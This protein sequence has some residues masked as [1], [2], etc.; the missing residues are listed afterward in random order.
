MRQCIK[1]SLNFKILPSFPDFFPQNWICLS[2]GPW[3]TGKS[4]TE[5]RIL[6]SVNSQYD[7]RLFIDLQLQYKK[8]T[9]LEQV[10]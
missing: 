10:V 3:F 6:E 5:E 2:K 9:F 4:L 8:N 1:I 7:D